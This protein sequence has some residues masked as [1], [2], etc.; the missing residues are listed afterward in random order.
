MRALLL[1]PLLATPA[2]A[3]GPSF[4]CTRATTPSEKAICASPELSQLDRQ[5]AAAYADALIAGRED[6]RALQRAWL[7]GRDAC[8][9]DPACLAREMHDRIGA[10][11]SPAPAHDR[12]A[13]TGAYCPDDATG[14]GFTDKGDHA[15][16]GFG[17]FFAN[18]HACGGMGLVATREG[19]DY[20]VREGACTITVTPGATGF[21]VATPTPGDC[22]PLYCG[23]RGMLT[24]FDVPYASRSPRVSDPEHWSWFEDGC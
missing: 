2:L 23:A 17:Q 15:V 16:I 21:H 4:N 18:G 13:L 11:A 8:Q 1:L 6:Q 22:Q 10:L 7:A 24:E 9:A 14:F 3:Q 5:L 19:Q 12:P 20:V